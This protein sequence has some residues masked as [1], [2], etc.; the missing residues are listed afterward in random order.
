M[1]GISRET[2]VRIQPV[3]SIE[4]RGDGII[5]L[6]AEAIKISFAT[7]DLRYYSACYVGLVEIRDCLYQERQGSSQSHGVDAPLLLQ[8]ILLCIIP[9]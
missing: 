8:V 6:F 4:G 5:F 1:R 3:S 2:L 7:R 9:L